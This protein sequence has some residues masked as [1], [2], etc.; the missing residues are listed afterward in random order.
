M[1]MMVMMMSASPAVCLIALAFLSWSCAHDAVRKPLHVLSAG[2]AHP[3]SSFTGLTPAPTVLSSSSSRPPTSDPGSPSPERLREDAALLELHEPRAERLLAQ[4]RQSSV[5]DKAQDAGVITTSDNS[6]DL[7]GFQ[8]RDLTSGRDKSRDT[9]R[10]VKNIAELLDYYQEQVTRLTI[11]S[12][13]ILILLR[14][15]SSSR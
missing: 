3:Q 5:S 12:Q 13:H 10:V 11:V 8:G 14:F 2:D 1:V 9:I 4:R 7:N 15:L 6:Q